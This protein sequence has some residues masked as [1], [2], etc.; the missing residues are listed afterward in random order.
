[1]IRYENTK[2]KIHASKF[3]TNK[4]EEKN[5]P[6]SVKRVFFVFIFDSYIS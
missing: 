6:I 5:K 2:R 3:V 1:M 4:F